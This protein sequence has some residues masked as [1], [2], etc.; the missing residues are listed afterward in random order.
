MV[1]VRD[2]LNEGG[3]LLYTGKYAG[4]QFSNAYEYDPAANAP[5]DPDSA[6]DFCHLLSDDFL[7]YWLGAYITID[8]L[9]MSPE[10]SPYD[11]LGFDAP[12]ID[13]TWSLGHPSA[14]NQD[15]TNSFLA[16]SALLPPDRY[17]QF[18]SWP[19]A[20][21]QIPGSPFAPHTGSRYAYSQIADQSYKRL[22]RTV[23]LAGQTSGSL[24]FWTSYRTE[25]T[26]DFLVVEAHTVGQDDWTT[27]PDQN[28]H[29][30]TDTG[31]SCAAGWVDIHP[32]TA[33]YQTFDRAAAT[34][35]PT[36]TTGTWNA[37]TGDSGGWQQWNVDLSAYAGKQVEVSIT[38]ISD[39]A[40]QDLGVFVDDVQIST[41][42]STSFEDGNGGWTASSAPGSVPVSATWIVDD[43]SSL[44]EGT[45]IVTPQ[46][47]FLGF[48]LEGVAGADT[49]AEIMGRVLRQLLERPS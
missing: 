7:Q 1:Q 19:A 6:A 36:G 39:W 15:H 4:T 38:Y 33:H 37:A 29:T 20:R 18:Q 26:W 45:A 49:R 28:G 22:A 2:Y 31:Q 23:D 25:P 27:L 10:G 43:G 32:F 47:V 42:D 35:T 41:G 46:T 30:S 8:G 9:G 24:S 3:H 17:P 21:F 5:C 16:T 11:V 44:K 14:R 40:T 48:G 34:C 13:L 12:F